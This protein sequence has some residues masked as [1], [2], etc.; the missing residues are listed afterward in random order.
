[1]ASIAGARRTQSSYTTFLAGTNPS[2]LSVAVYNPATDG[3]PGPPL[4][5]KI[6]HLPG[7]KRVKSLVTPTLVPLTADGAPRLSTSLNLWSRWAVSTGSC[8]RR[9]A[10]RPPKDGWPTRSGR[11][12]S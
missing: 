7:V 4:R 12:R 11:T 2:D 3:G 6:A 1:M 8:S 10:S 9:T 5:A